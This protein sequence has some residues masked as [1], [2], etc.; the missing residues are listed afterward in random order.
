M[1]PIKRIY[2]CCVCHETLKKELDAPLQ[3]LDSDIDELKKNPCHHI[4]G[5]Q[6]NQAQGV[7]ATVRDNHVKCLKYLMVCGA[8][9]STK[10]VD[11]AMQYNRGI[12]LKY[13]ISV[14]CPGSHD[15]AVKKYM[16]AS[17]ELYMIPHD[18]AM[19]VL[20]YYSPTDD[21]KPKPKLKHINR[22]ENKF[23]T[24]NKP[25]RIRINSTKPILDKIPDD[26]WGNFSKK[27][28]CIIC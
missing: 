24:F 17:T 13:L 18:V 3:A 27:L 5:M 4:K 8:P 2:S 11:M 21:P 14:N 7:V 23:D 25:P 26:T 22:L 12:C 28:K 16:I 19:I 15:I 9:L 1:Q 6:R 10:A 20:D